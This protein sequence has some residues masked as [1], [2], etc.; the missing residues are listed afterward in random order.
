MTTNIAKDSA[1]KI[2]IYFDSANKKR[3]Y[4][5]IDN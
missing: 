5:F 2:G 4:K 1:F 3:S